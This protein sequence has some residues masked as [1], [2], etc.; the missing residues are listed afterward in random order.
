MV[1]VE[2]VV[3]PAVVVVVELSVEEVVVFVGDV[4]DV[5]SVVP[6]AVEVVGCLV[7]K[8]FIL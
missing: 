6:V 8:G 5:D 1:V 2:G 7:V 4:L 3:V